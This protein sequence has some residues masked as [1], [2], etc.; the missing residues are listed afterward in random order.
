M[1]KV[2]RC[3]SCVTF[4]LV[5]VCAGCGPKEEVTTPSGPAPTMADPN[6]FNVGGNLGVPGTP[7]ASGT[8]APGASGTA[9][10]GTAA[11]GTK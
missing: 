2:L 7:G 3:L 1:K 9:V 10:P 6:S 4:T 5:V 11:P 8:P